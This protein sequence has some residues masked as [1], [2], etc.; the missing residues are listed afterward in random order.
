MCVVVD[1]LVLVV[2][3]S[4]DVVS[5]TN[6]PAGVL[7]V[8]GAEIL[9]G[10]LATVSAP[11]ILLLAVVGATATLV[12]PVKVAPASLAAADA[13]GEPAEVPQY[14]SAKATTAAWSA[15]EQALWTA[16]VR[17]EMSVGLEQMQW[18]SVG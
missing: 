13:P 6:D 11:A 17:D 16:V 8:A 2:K 7:A 15:G 10:K 3:V 5:T 4:M 18:A 12:V 14:V 9:D 1:E